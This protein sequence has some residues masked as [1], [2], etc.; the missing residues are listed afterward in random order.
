MGGSDSGL[1]AMSNLS[2]DSLL[3]RIGCVCVC[4]RAR[5]CARVLR[6]ESLLCFVLTFVLTFVF[7]LCLHL[8]H[9]CSQEADQPPPPPTPH[10][11]LYMSVGM[12]LWFSLRVFLCVPLC[13]RALIFF[14]RCG[15]IAC[16]HEVS[17]THP[18]T[19]TPTYTHTQARTHA[20]AHAHTPSSCARSRQ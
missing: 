14:H 2:I 1:R 18:P 13:E 15:H 4:A 5:A 20:C 7:T 9:L 12:P 10:F 19:P 11:G 3:L 16:T 17:F 6:C 8:C